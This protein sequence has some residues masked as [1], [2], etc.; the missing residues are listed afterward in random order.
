MVVSVPDPV[1]VNTE[2]QGLK[3]VALQLNDKLALQRSG[4]SQASTLMELRNVLGA[5]KEKE[6][7]VAAATP[8]SEPAQASV[9]QSIVV[10]GTE[11]PTVVTVP[12]SMFAVP[13]EITVPGS[14]FAVPQEIPRNQPVEF[15]RALIA[16]QD[17]I[18]RQRLQEENAA[19]IQQREQYVRGAQAREAEI[20]RELSR[21]AEDVRR[22]D[23][24]R[25]VAEAPSFEDLRK[26]SP[27]AV[28]VTP[29]E[30]EAIQSFVMATVKSNKGYKP[31]SVD[32]LM[33]AKKEIDEEK[34]NIQFQRQADA[35]NRANRQIADP[36][37]TPSE[38]RTTAALQI[39]GRSAR[40]RLLAE[41]DRRDGDRPG[42]VR[43]PSSQPVPTITPAQLAMVSREIE[44]DRAPANTAQ[45]PP[46]SNPPEPQSEMAIP[47]PTV[48]GSGMQHVTA[49]TF[50]SS[51]WTTAS[52]LRW[53]RSNGLH[54]IR[55]STKINGAYSY[56][57]QSPAGYSSFN[58]VKMSHKN[59][60]FTIV[61][62]TPK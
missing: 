27:T 21:A 46:P 11:A 35:L 55:K 18:D 34:R 6:R 4:K 24:D 22:A 51:K 50:P 44:T 7:E 30:L 31:G 10:P 20:A 33:A 28:G 41:A 25:R 49:A 17:A 42:A 38:L 29:E 56:A 54:P 60:D 59:K 8:S 15:Q 40:E 2:L 19:L 9:P 61:Y 58:S 3:L 12:G 48:N 53:L 47:N 32:A 45:I 52:S 13:Q 36:K 16:S 26:A 37:T 14:M 5:I 23:I 1:A 43:E 57:L 62:G 39:L